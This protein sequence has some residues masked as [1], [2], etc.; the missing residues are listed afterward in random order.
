MTKKILT[1]H[2]PGVRPPTPKHQR[3]ITTTQVFE[4]QVFVSFH[5][6]F[7][8]WFGYFYFACF[9]YFSSFFIN[10]SQSI[11]Y[12]FFFACWLHF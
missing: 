4:I 5:F 2:S 6:D 10:F 7:V 9:F 11:T 1:S 12:L 3:A 8:C